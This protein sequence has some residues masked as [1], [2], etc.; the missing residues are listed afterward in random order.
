MTFDHLKFIEVEL[1][2]PLMMLPVRTSLIELERAR[3]LWSPASTLTEAQLREAGEVTDIIAPNLLHGGGM[4]A[5]AA[6]HPRAR[7]WGPAGIK[8]K[9]PELSWHGVLGADPWPYDDELRHVALRGMP[10]FNESVFLHHR[11]KVLLVSDLVFNIEESRGL[12]PWLILHLF[13][14]YRRLAVSRLFL[15]RVK[16]RAAFQ[17]SIERLAALDFSHVA[18]AHGRVVSEEGK[19]KLLA[20]LRERGYTA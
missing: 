13:G 3:V 16:D 8:E 11:S 20:A 6:A 4:K 1:Q 7:L 15:R 12:G 19:Q 17:E 14:T 2:M 10:D 5:A 9:F 18:P